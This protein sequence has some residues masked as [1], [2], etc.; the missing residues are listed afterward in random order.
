M[1]KHIGIGLGLMILSGAAFAAGPVTPSQIYDAATAGGNDESLK[2][3]QT[4][5]GNP[6]GLFPTV[7]GPMPG[8]G[9]FQSLF[10]MFNT[11]ILTVGLAWLTYGV[12]GGLVQTAHEGEFLGKRMS[13]TWI[14][15]R[16]TTG[17]ATLVPFVNGWSIGQL[18][19]YF[20]G[21]LGIGMANLSTS[22]LASGV[23]TYMADSS[24]A[25]SSLSSVGLTANTETVK[26]MYAMFDI[27]KKV[28]G[29][30][31][32]LD[33]GNADNSI[34][35][36]PAEYADCIIGAI[37]IRCDTKQNL[38]SAGAKSGFG[39]IIKP[40]ISEAASGAREDIKAISVA[41][42]QA[43]SQA[44]DTA[45]GK[46]R[47]LAKTVTH[48]SVDGL[49][50]DNISTEV[51]K[52]AKEYDAQVASATKSQEAYI[53]SMAS[54]AIARAGS[55]ENGGWV[56][57]GTSYK[58]LA[59][60]LSNLSKI[61]RAGPSIIAPEG[62]ESEMDTRSEA[63]TMKAKMEDLPKDEVEVFRSVSTAINRGLASLGANSS[64]T[65]LVNPLVVAQNM[66]DYITLAGQAAFVARSVVFGTAK[67][68]E[69]PTVDTAIPVWGNAKRAV[70][71]LLESLVAP[72]LVLAGILFWV[73]AWL[74]VYVPMI[75]FI[76]FWA[77]IVTWLGVFAE[78][79]I[80]A[81]LWSF[82]HLDTDGEGLGQ[83]TQYGYIF[84][85][86]VL[87]RPVL[88]VFGFIAASL[89]LLAL[90][91]LFL[92]LYNMAF[93]TAGYNNL[94]FGGII[95][96]VGGVVLFAILLVGMVQGAFNMVSFIPD[97]VLGWVGGNVG[98]KLGRRVEDDGGKFYGAAVMNPGREA[99]A[100]IG[101]LGGDASTG[102][103]AS[104]G[105][106]KRAPGK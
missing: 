97:Q 46:L 81:P 104:A 72:L 73:G 92:K 88:M 14:P 26:K 56:S 74:S 25:V 89:S 94:D 102:A 4:V 10:M 66:G 75:P 44:I 98:D 53:N 47:S 22:Y 21:V 82:A 7:G 3:I 84:L 90:G 57:L 96:L 42:A 76:A 85:L 62:A 65:H 79:L 60:E 93:E 15:I 31:A 106:K 52:V 83:R 19:V 54:Q 28:E 37:D 68:A 17:I 43:Q 103:D 58:Y 24:A 35:Y 9:V 38:G 23:G 63:D 16:L 69:A 99:A 80:A 55:A 86:N 50:S 101:H 64:S 67:A 71:G 78:G 77:G 20:C 91:T 95:L 40:T 5:F 49:P 6:G 48:A 39:R 33:A 2:L 70:A 18:F 61:S 8:D 59:E 36:D 1:N 45:F 29:H 41:L 12:V 87:M 100:H 105:G 32:T 13:T 11:L 30:N 51:N 27:A 34:P